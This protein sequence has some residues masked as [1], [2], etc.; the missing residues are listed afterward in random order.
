M[1]GVRMTNGRAAH[2]IKLRRPVGI[3]DSSEHLDK[4][5][6]ACRPPRLHVF[7]Y[8]RVYLRIDADGLYVIEAVR[9]SKFG[10]AAFQHGDGCGPRYIRALMNMTRLDPNGSLVN[11]L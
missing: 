2:P 5:Y 8:T 10:K 1:G 9:F 3:R 4:R 6:E 7:A 11:L